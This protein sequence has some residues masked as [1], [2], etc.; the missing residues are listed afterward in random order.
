M[1]FDVDA[2]KADLVSISAHKL[3]GPK[4]IGA[5]YVRSKPRVRLEP[6]FSG[7]GQE[8]GLRPGTLPTAL[9][10]GFGEA[11]AIA[12]AERKEETE[13][14]LA[15]RARLLEG[16][17][18]CLDGVVVNG[19]L[20]RRAPGNLNVSFTGVNS[21]TL[22]MELRDLAVSSGA[23]CSSATHEPSYVL[24]ALGVG[25]AVARGS[26]RIGLGRFTT[27]EEIDYAIG[28]FAEMVEKLRAQRAKVGLEPT[29]MH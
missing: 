21:E 1:D 22:M 20:H 13:R 24:K 3:Y 25:E 14:L 17:R 18:A 5:L 8:Q 9:C 29:A 23:A 4:G 10:V 16:L 28:A 26:I 6:L 19:T 27:Q 7:G 11:V 15:L 2:A 12:M